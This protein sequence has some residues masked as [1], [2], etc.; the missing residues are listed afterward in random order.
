MAAGTLTNHMR[1]KKRQQIRARGVLILLRHLD[2][3]DVLKV[4][5]TKQP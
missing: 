5:K 2:A 4:K 1:E 3:Q